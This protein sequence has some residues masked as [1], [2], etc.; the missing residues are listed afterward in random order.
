MPKCLCVGQ[1]EHIH[2]SP[3]L[4]LVELNLVNILVFINNPT[5]C[6]E[7]F[8]KD[9]SYCQEKCRLIVE[10]NLATQIEFQDIGIDF[11]TKNSITANC[12]NQLESI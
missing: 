3:S 12:N 4:S 1:T 10:G 9:L 6:V 5:V 7:V 8:L 2:A 11:S